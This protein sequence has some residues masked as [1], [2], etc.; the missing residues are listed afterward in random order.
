VAALIL[1]RARAQGAPSAGGQRTDDSAQRSIEHPRLIEHHADHR[2]GTAVIGT[3][4][5]F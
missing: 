1:L 5:A 4:A 3:T 2:F